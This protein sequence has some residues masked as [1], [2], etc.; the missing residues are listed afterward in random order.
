MGIVRKGI[1]SVLPKIEERRSEG[2]QFSIN[3]EWVVNAGTV[4][5]DQKSGLGVA[6]QRVE[7]MP[8]NV[9][10]QTASHCTF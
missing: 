3:L 9:P 4:S 1:D 2:S 8:R 10:Y 6:L 5:V 7:G